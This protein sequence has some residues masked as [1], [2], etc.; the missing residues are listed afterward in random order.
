MIRMVDIILNTKFRSIAFT[1]I[2]TK[3]KLIF[4]LLSNP[5][6]ENRAIIKE[7]IVEIMNP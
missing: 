1:E 5:Y 4:Y 2:V 3:F 6:K 7:K